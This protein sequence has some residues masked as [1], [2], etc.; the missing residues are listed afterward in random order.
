VLQSLA[1]R[2]SGRGQE[3]VAGIGIEDRNFIIGHGWDASHRV[4]VV[5]GLAWPQLLLLAWPQL[6]LLESIVGVVVVGLAWPQLRENEE[7]ERDDDALL[8]AFDSKHSNQYL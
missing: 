6:L 7:I 8:E 3:T 4:V 1:S 2:V 5:V